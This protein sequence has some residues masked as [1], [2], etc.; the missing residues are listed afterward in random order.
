[1][2]LKTQSQT[3][4][5]MLFLLVLTLAFSSGTLLTQGVAASQTLNVL[6]LFKFV[7]DFAVGSISLGIVVAII[8]NLLKSKI[9]DGYADTAST[10]VSIVLL[11]LIFIAKALYPNITLLGL[12]NL[13]SKLTEYSPLWIPALAWLIRF[14]SGEAHEVLRGIPFI[15]TSHYKPPIGSS[16]ARFFGTG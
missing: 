3:I 10:I 14:V 16:R 15:G 4:P 12:E 9:P 6:E 13:F 7:Q 5:V 11:S 8:I 2:L 1:M